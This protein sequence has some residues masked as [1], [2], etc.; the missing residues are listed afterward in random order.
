MALKFTEISLNPDVEQ[1][2]SLIQEQRFDELRD[3]IAKLTEISITYDV[4][5]Q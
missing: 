3:F 2:F 4:I 1:I 5:V